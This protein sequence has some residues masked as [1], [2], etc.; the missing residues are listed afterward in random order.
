MGDDGAAG[1]GK[2]DPA[3]TSSDVGG[4]EAG[5]GSARRQ[6][7]SAEQRPRRPYTRRVKHYRAILTKARLV[8]TGS[9]DGRQVAASALCMP[10]AQ[11]LFARN[12]ASASL[13]HVC[14]G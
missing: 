12:L 8:A 7:S 4:D 5:T 3:S 6:Q 10:E 11:P 9:W 14:L 13:Y 1:R 2:C